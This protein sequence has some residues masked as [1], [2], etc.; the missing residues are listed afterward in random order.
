MTDARA[1]AR[2]PQATPLEEGVPDRLK[3]HDFRYS[4]LLNTRENA[5]KASIQLDKTTSVPKLHGTLGITN[6]EYTAYVELKRPNGNVDTLV[7]PG[8]GNATWVLTLDN[9]P[10]GRYEAAIVPREEKAFEGTRLTFTL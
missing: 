6:T 3:P 2:D 1:G 5:M 8:S 7:V 4:S 9:C 10:A